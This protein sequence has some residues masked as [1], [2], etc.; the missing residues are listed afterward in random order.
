MKAPRR[1]DDL[2]LFDLGGPYQRIF[3]PPIEA[4]QSTTI[5]T[6]LDFGDYALELVGVLLL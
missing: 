1:E 2:D 3:I 4:G 6:S 5:N